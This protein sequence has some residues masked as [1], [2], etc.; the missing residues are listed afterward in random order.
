MAHCSEILWLAH[1][2]N[3]KIKEVPITVIYHHY[4]QN[5]G[6]G[7]RIL[8]DLFFNKLNN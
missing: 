6:G 2:Q 7:V 1:K 5:F 4:G 8:K 3:L